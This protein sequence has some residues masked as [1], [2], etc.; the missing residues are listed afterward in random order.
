MKRKKVEF[1]KQLARFAIAI[2]IVSVIA[3][4]TFAALGLDTVENLTGI[5]VTTCFAYL[6]TYAATS[7]LEKHSR[8]KYHIRE[9]GTP[10]TE[11]PNSET[12]QQNGTDTQ[13][14]STDDSVAG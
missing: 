12:S 10:Y 3:S 4:Y 14:T 2:I 8:N 9:D 5:I 7:T 1:K 6:V 13:P 11:P